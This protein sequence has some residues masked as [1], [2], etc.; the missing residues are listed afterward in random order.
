MMMMRERPG[1][2]RVH[3]AANTHS[4]GMKSPLLAEKKRSMPAGVSCCRASHSP[5]PKADEVNPFIIPARTQPF[6]GGLS[7]T[8]GPLVPLLLPHHTHQPHA[9]DTHT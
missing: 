3:C 7:S 5:P 4:Q 9:L 8:A 1:C 2:L 6:A